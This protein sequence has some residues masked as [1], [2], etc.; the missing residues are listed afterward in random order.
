M[1]ESSNELRILSPT[2]ILGYG[3]PV[4]SFEKGMALAPHVVAVD[5]GSTDP[6]PYY[7]GAGISFTDRA[8]VK[9]DVKII[10]CATRKAGIP[11]IVGSAGGAG[12]TPHLEWLADIVREIAY[13][14]NLSFKMALI[15]SEIDKDVVLSALLAGE[16]KPCGT[17]DALN[18]ER[19]KS[20]ERIVAQIG[21]EPIIVALKE[22]VDVVIAGRTYD[23]A[24]FAA[25][26]VMKGFDEG[27]ALHMG[28]IL[29]CAAIACSPGSGSDCMFAVLK[30]D[31]F[32]IH[33]LNETRKCTV[34]SVA[35][36]TLY[37]KSNPTRLPGPGGV[38][39]LTETVFEQ[40]ND[41]TVKV[42][43]SK[44]IH[45]AYELK[46]EGAALSGYRTVSFAG[47]RDPIFISQIDEIIKAVRDRTTDNFSDYSESDYKL[48]FR[49]Y[50]KNGVMGESEPLAD[51]VPHEIG[52]II[53]AVARTQLLA[54]TIC[55]F[56]RSTMLHY[57]YPGRIST[58]GNLAFPYS[59]SD[60]KA[61]EVYGFSVYHL[62]RARD[63][64][65]H[66]KNSF[67]TVNGGL[68]GQA[69]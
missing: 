47:V 11:F 30:D 64:L 26:P 53:D 4:S 22:D 45:T 23:P 66:S 14:E 57:G 37:E 8:A 62:M 35:A 39:D 12:G 41:N 16:I 6:G 54:N 60:F 51:A 7:L 65:G 58:A 13:E 1:S 10:L 28:K 31:H 29:E 63:P 49:V 59:P 32:L 20:S 44:H 18:P 42:S 24:V 50:G 56:A 15:D 67:E 17:W 27:L 21:V 40:L 55:G 34:N 52:I 19:I 3:F 2:A 68:N 9:R 48:Y 38:L 5:A 46:L 25:L 36:H 69:H 61:G 33:P 43:G